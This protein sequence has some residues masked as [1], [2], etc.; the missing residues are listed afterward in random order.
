M[1]ENPPNRSGFFVEPTVFAD[2]R[3]DMRIAQEEVFGPFTVVIPFDDEEDAIRIANDSP[4]GLA[5]AV[6]TR[7]IARAHRVADRIEAGIVWINDHHR[8]DAASPWG[9]F[10]LSGIGREFGQ[11]AFD[12][13]FDVK[14]VMLNTGDQPFDW[15]DMAA[16]DTRLN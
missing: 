4:Y 12:A 6:R 1:P 9:G 10:K 13:Y 2:V 8:V 14:A 11:E 16:G 5:A 15:Y 3:P 7:D